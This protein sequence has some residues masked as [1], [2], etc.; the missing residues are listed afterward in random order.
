MRT[1][2]FGFTG[3]TK[4]SGRKETDHYLFW[5]GIKIYTH[6]SY[7]YIYTHTRERERE[8]DAYECGKSVQHEVNLKQCRNLEEIQARA[9]EL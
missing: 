6:I 4:G 3:E 5:R 7:I 2:S 9:T 8:R 1:T